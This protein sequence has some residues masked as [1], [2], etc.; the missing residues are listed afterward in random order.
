VSL[1]K[2]CDA[3]SAQTYL[4]QPANIRKNI[5]EGYKPRTLKT[6]TIAIQAYKFVNNFDT[7]DN[8]NN[9]MY[10]NDL[11]WHDI[12]LK[13]FGDITFDY[14][15]SYT[16]Y[17]HIEPNI[18]T[19]GL[20]YLW[21]PQSDFNNDVFGK[22][23]F[24]PIGLQSVNQ[25]NWVTQWMQQRISQMQQME[26]VH[27]FTTVPGDSNRRAGDIVNITLPSPEP[28]IED[29][30]PVDAYFSDNYLVSSIRHIINKRQYIS[31]LDLVKDSIFHAY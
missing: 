18:V 26:N 10:T 21:T 6:D 2:L 17:K 13:Q 4:F 12:Q 19:G 3:P 1:E 24:Y 22:H 30:M 31:V 29:Q 8:I 16:N 15:S 25:Q 14:P 5:P 11:L 20:S 9:G 28:P 23:K 7:L 27:M